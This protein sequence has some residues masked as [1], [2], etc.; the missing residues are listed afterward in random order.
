MWC[1]G[2]RPRHALVIRLSIQCDAGAAGI[3]GSDRGQQPS[4]QG[5]SSKKTPLSR[6]NALPRPGRRPISPVGSSY[7]LPRTVVTSPLPSGL[8]SESTCTIPVLS[9]GAATVRERCVQ[10]SRIC[11]AVQTGTRSGYTTTPV[12]TG[13]SHSHSSRWQQFASRSR[14]SFRPR[15]SEAQMASLGCRL[16]PGLWRCSAASPRRCAPASTVM[17]LPGG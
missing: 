17:H 10:N 7:R 5:V 3:A 13:S 1:A 11:T 4:S 16:R 2:T 6:N 8:E 9:F 15:R 12:G 14:A